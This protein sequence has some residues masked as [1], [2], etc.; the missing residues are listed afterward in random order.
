MIASSSASTTRTG[1]LTGR[2]AHRRR[3][4]SGRRVELGGHAVEERVLLALELATARRSA[5]RCRLCASAWRRT[6]SGL[7]V[8]DRRL[9]HERAQ[10]GVFGLGLEER[11]LLVGDR[12]LGAQPLEAVAHVDEAALEQRE[13]SNHPVYVAASGVA[14]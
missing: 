7:G 12:E 14:P 6:S 5:S 8:G 11:A 4:E 9:R 3:E 10:P 2:T 1:L 13:A